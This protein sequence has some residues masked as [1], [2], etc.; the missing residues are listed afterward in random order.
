MPLKPVLRGVA[1]NMAAQNI[2][3][4]FGFERFVW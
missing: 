3:K 2:L 1:E 4:K